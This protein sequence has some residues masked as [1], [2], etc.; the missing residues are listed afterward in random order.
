MNTQPGKKKETIT[1]K[2]NLTISI[3]VEDIFT[4]FKRRTRRADI[5][6]K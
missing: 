5:I 3:V 2:Q 4:I 6:K 1:E